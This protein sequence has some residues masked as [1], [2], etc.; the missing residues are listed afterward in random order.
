MLWLHNDEELA[1]E[2]LI[3]RSSR[4][5]PT[6]GAETGVHMSHNGT[7]NISRDGA[8][9]CTRVLVLKNG[10]SDM[11]G[12]ERQG[13]AQLSRPSSLSNGTN[14][15]HGGNISDSGG[16]GNCDANNVMN[17]VLRSPEDDVD[18]SDLGADLQ[19]IEEW[20]KTRSDSLSSFD[21][22]PEIKSSEVDVND[23]L[24]LKSGGQFQ[25]VGQEGSEGSSSSG[26][27]LNQFSFSEEGLGGSSGSRRNSF[28][29]RL[30]TLMQV[31]KGLFEELL[32]TDPNRRQGN[33]KIES[34]P[35]LPGEDRGLFEELL[36][37]GAHEEWARQAQELLL[38]VATEKKDGAGL[39]GQEGTGESESPLHEAMECSVSVSSPKTT[40][41]TA[42]SGGH[43]TSDDLDLMVRSIQ[44]I[45]L[46]S[47][48]EIENMASR[49]LGFDEA[50]IKSGIQRIGGPASVC[51]DEDFI[52]LP[53]GAQEGEEGAAMPPD[54]LA[55]HSNEIDSKLSSI[56][57]MDAS[58][59]TLE[60]LG[61]ET[62]TLEGLSK[63]VPKL[64]RSVSPGTF[65]VKL[66]P[67]EK[68]EALGKAASLTTGL[69][70]AAAMPPP[71]AILTST[72]PPQQQQQSQ[73]LPLLHP[74]TTRTATTSLITTPF[75]A[76]PVLSIGSGLMSKATSTPLLA[77]S[78]V[79]DNCSA[80]TTT[81]TLTST[82][83]ITSTTFCSSSSTTSS[84][85]IAPKRMIKIPG[86]RREFKKLPVGV[87]QLRIGP[88]VTSS[89]AT[90]TTTHT[91]TTTSAATTRPALIFRPLITSQSTL[92]QTSQAKT[93]QGSVPKEG[94]ALS[95]TPVKM[96]PLQ[97]KPG[98]ANVTITVDRRANLTSVSIVS[99]N[100]EHTVF[101]INTCD[102]VRA[103]SSI[104]EPHLDP[105]GLT[106]QQLLRSAHTAH[107]LIQEVHQHGV[108]R[109]TKGLA[110][111]PVPGP[112]NFE[113][114]QAFQEVK[115]PISRSQQG[116]LAVLRQAAS[117]TT[118]PTV[119]SGGTRIVASS[120]SNSAVRP[121]I[122]GTAPLL[123]T[124]PTSGP[125]IIPAPVTSAMN[126][127]VLT[128]VKSEVSSNAPHRVS[129]ESTPIMQQEPKPS[130][131]DQAAM[132]DKALGECLAVVFLHRF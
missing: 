97:H 61:A 106:P 123:T 71:Q 89:S 35:S 4:G 93:Q 114:N 25:V 68:R 73:Q 13:V 18:T 118:T 51:I 58:N 121:T 81:T 32:L 45:K 132:L 86:A 36:L 53:F 66:E 6:G 46:M 119:Q 37:P 12:G 85:G 7:L 10:G 59:D 115:A 23:F 40:T 16:M 96:I 90:P 109:P 72:P 38:A 108:V 28:T 39:P 3:D 116:Q 110:K 98:T 128:T 62:D 56:L 34:L 17:G 60:I 48:Q 33:R 127:T 54:L 69:S 103:V 26:V 120:S 77:T 64:E 20:L 14:S 129:G 29:K 22:D 94:S 124:V 43:G 84:P 76:L 50:P 83:T 41:A 105:L 9:E 75:Q 95:F 24:N 107:R 65:L 112:Q 88:P 11:A 104:R 5:S 78:I 117:S 47:P 70:L 63:V 80:T 49:P 99:S 27:M 19:H 2:P 130:C 126:S 52:F 1:C 122:I 131:P 67:R 55:S 79:T 101:K 74:L 57:A 30:E 87:V 92:P 8:G 113:I 42:E 125:V 15:Q 21:F 102:L 100:G 82:T 44:P 31:D 111:E 91:P